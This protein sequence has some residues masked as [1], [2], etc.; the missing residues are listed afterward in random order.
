MGRAYGQL[1]PTIL[2]RL[3]VEDRTAFRHG[4][5]RILD[6]PFERVVVAH[7]SVSAEGGRDQLVRG[8]RWVLDSE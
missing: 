2:E 3:L 4:L 5:E 6:W 7:G 8:Y 1:V